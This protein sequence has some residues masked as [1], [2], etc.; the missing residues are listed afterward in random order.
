[1]QNAFSQT[2]GGWRVVADDRWLA[3]VAGLTGLVGLLAVVVGLGRP[4]LAGGA[5]PVLG[6]GFGVLSALLF[7]RLRESAVDGPSDRDLRTHVTT[8][9]GLSDLLLDSD[10][11]PA[12]RAW[13]LDI[14]DAAA[15]LMDGAGIVTRPAAAA[16]GPGLRVLVAEDNPTNQKVIHAMLEKLGHR[17]EMV[18]DGAGAVAAAAE[19][20]CD[21]IIMDV[22]MPGMDG[23][24]ATRA[25]REL[26][27]AA[28][29]VPVLAVTASAMAEDAAACRAAGMN[30]HL[31]KPVDRAALAAGLAG[32][33][34][35]AGAVADDLVDGAM[36]AELRA[37]V[38]AGAVSQFVATFLDDTRARLDRAAAADRDDDIAALRAELHSIAGAAGGIG[39][40]GVVRACQAVRAGLD[41]PGRRG[42]RLA[43]LEQAVDAVAAAF[44][45]AE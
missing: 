18:G 11:A 25:I 10:L 38:G 22:Q 3:A 41:D 1:M 4:E 6:L 12:Q 14:R 27:G 17:V 26:P 36:M 35:A 15:G 24:A 32:L 44:P 19:G 7:R 16:A 8:V 37:T 13:V 39:L 34:P 43:P 29:A 45:L 28:G 21:I 33:V 20:R 2:A 40:A 5:V 9:I 30:G 31:A 42:L 23:L